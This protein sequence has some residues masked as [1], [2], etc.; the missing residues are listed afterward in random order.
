MLDVKGTNVDGQVTGRQFYLADTSSIVGPCI[1]VADVGGPPNAY[2]QVKSRTKWA[3]EFEDWLRQP[4]Q[5][6]EMVLTDEDE[7]EENPSINKRARQG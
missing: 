1:V 5:H 3:K 2:F 7:E 4:H 6:D